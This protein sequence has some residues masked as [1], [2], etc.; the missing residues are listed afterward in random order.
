MSA[1]L[2][3][4]LPPLPRSRFVQLVGWITI[5]LCSIG[6]LV[7][8]METAAFVAMTRSSLGTSLQ[9]QL[10]SHPAAASFFAT[11]TRW[12]PWVAG[13]MVVQLV[14]HLVAAIGLLK[15]LEGARRAFVG[16]LWFDASWQCALIP[17]QWWLMARVQ[18]M[19]LG[20]APVSADPRM[21]AQWQSSLIG[22]HLVGVATGLAFVGLYLWLARHLSTPR[23]R[24][25]FPRHSAHAIARDH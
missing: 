19:A 11:L 1:A 14:V 22:S 16:M 3:P 15:R 9:S 17:M 4:P 13:V 21:Q 7:L 5:A 10:E 2:P 25:E 23:V 12:L 8:A 20:L 18:T 24:A 6:L